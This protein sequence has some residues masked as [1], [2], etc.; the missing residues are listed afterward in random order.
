MNKVSL[1]TLGL[2][3]SVSAFARP[4]EIVEPEVSAVFGGSGNVS[5]K[6]ECVAVGV[7]NAMLG[8]QPII[9]Y[10]TDKVKAYNAAIG[11][12]RAMVS[13]GND[14]RISDKFL[15]QDVSAG[16]PIVDG[17][18]TNKIYSLLGHKRVNKMEDCR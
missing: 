14:P 5:C 12:C 6:A 17:K 1:A 18:L 3:L 7:D 10:G 11:V 9:G 4:P 15:A 8:Q 16:Y 2:L 13:F